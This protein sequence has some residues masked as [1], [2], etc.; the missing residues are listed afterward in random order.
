MP[1]QISEIDKA[2]V[3]HSKWKMRLKKA[4][5]T[6]VSD[7]TPAVAMTDN[8]CEF[9]RW[10]YSI[11]ATERTAKH[12]NTVQNLHAQFHQVA[13]SCL[14]CALSGQRVQAKQMMDLGGPFSRAT[15]QLTTAMIEWKQALSRNEN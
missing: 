13:G 1:V 12:W 7:V 5:D 11:A 14:H 10:L 2:I 15:S 3:A 6:G 4:I 8:Q 9:G